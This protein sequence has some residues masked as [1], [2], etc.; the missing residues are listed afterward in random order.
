M[1]NKDNLIE[2]WLYDINHMLYKRL[3]LELREDLI[4][5]VPLGFPANEYNP[6]HE[7]VL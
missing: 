4:A 2:Q 5:A 1:S 6:G 3:V 7:K